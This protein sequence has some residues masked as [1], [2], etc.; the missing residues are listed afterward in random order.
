[1]D[2][3]TTEHEY[4]LSIVSATK[5]KMNASVFRSRN[6]RGCS[7]WAKAALKMRS[8]ARVHAELSLR[9]LIVIVP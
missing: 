9:R 2:D 3:L 1:M 5:V 7:I 6:L 4:D 8:T